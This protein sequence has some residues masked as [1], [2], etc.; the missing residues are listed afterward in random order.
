MEIAIKRVCNCGS[1]T[2]KAIPLAVPMKTLKKVPA[3][4][5]HAI[6]KPVA[7]PIVLTLR[8]FLDSVN[9]LT[10]ID[11]LRPTRY[12][13][14]TCKT[15]LMGIICNPTCSVRYIITLGMY[16]GPSQQGATN[17]EGI[18]AP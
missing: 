6:N 17:P 9:A 16:P 14:I 12:D 8:F 4:V 5:G 7:A 1:A 13:T 11:V 3:Q 15:K 18:S 10:A 2:V